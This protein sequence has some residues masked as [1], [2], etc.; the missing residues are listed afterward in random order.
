M[1]MAAY[2]EDAITSETGYMNYGR[3]SRRET[4]WVEDLRREEEHSRAF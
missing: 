3:P 1:F 4:H 2:G